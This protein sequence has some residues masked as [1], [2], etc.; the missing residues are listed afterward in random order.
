MSPQRRTAIGG[1]IKLWEDIY[2]EYDGF[3]EKDIMLI[4]Y[5]NI[6]DYIDG[7]DILIIGF[8]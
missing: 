8:K 2:D 5:N 3:T 1:I 7:G 4:H 6:F